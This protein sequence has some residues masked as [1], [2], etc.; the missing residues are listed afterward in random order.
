VD[1]C[2]F[3]Y[4]CTTRFPHGTGGYEF[5]VSAALESL[6]S[7]SRKYEKCKSFTDLFQRIKYLIFITGKH[8][9]VAVTV[10]VLRV[11]TP[12]YPLIMI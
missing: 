5:I 9:Y 10:D 7:P 2:D 12:S 1:Y 4:E 3:G 6:L 11:H 8:L